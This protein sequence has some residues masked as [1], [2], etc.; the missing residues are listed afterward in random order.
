MELKNRLFTI[1]GLVKPVFNI[2]FF[3]LIWLN[4]ASLSACSSAKLPAIQQDDVIVAFGDSLTAGY[5][6]AKPFSY[7][8]VLAEM[9][10]L[11]VV[12]EG[13]SGETTA[14]GLERLDQ[15][16]ETHSPKLV[17]L[18]EGGNDVLQKVPEVQI[19][20]N[21]AKMINIIQNSGSAVLLVGVPEKKLFGSSLDLY[22]ELA[23]EFEIPL[24]E[25]IVANLMTRP[26]MKSDYVHFNQQGYQAMAE[27]IY[28][29][30]KSSGAI[31]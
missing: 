13:V 24:E 25:D 8:S 21:L 22:S 12:N 16:L 29:T 18:L 31:D 30:L 7:P 6:V 17:I 15:V 14:Q 11:T 2:L 20:A 19:K 1:P 27:A 4:I 23:K 10:G 3:A 26:S 9:T 28:Q 5:G